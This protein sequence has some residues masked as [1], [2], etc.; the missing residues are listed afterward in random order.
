MKSK[1]QLQEFLPHLSEQ[2][3]EEIAGALKS[4]EVKPELHRAVSVAELAPKDERTFVGYASTRGVDRDEEVI[5]PG[6]MSLDQFRKAPVL[7]WG[8]AWSSPPIGKDV[9][10][11]SDGYGLKTRSLMAETAFANELWILVKGGFQKTSSIG[12]IPLEWVG[13]SDKDYGTL[14]D[15]ARKWPEW[16]LKD[17]PKSFITK[18]ILLEHS[19]VAVPAQIDALITSIKQFNLPLL[20]KELKMA[21]VPPTPATPEAPKV[22][23]RLVKTREQLELELSLEV[24]AAVAR[25]LKFRKG[26]L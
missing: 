24:A 8:H 22:Y 17:E 3:Q 13:H 1:V 2:V 21:A 16:N 23:H 12:F 14:M 26:Q 4:T 25:E 7:L 15:T 20:S 5:L 11:E 18:A 6:G 9:L 10:I 19:L